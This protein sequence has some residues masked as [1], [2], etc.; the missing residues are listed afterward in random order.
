MT[1]D[2]PF[3]AGP[4]GAGAPP[5]PARRQALR[6]GL[7]L[8][9]ST[10]GLAASLSAAPAACL[11]NGDPPGA[12]R[13]AWPR[14]QATP[15]L[16]LPTWDGPA[17]R[18]ADARGQVVVINFWASWCEPCR[19]ELP[20]L[21]LLAQ[22]HLDD[23]VQVVTVNHRETDAAVRRYLAAEPLSLPVLRDRDGAAS[24]AWGARVFPTTVVVDRKGRAA[25]SVIGELDWAGPAARR[26]MRELV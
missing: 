6:Q 23:R 9:T 4:A 24:R 5:S 17:W 7:S 16:E 25:F 8:L 22:R 26:W 12:Q 14:G 11:A 18:L 13:T 2:H 15:A 19:T 10:T 1:P 3:L 21:E 20:S